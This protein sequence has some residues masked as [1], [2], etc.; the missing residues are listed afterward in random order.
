MIQVAF[1]VSGHG[2]VG[3]LGRRLTDHHLRSDETSCPGDASGPAAPAATDR[4][5]G[6][7]ST[8]ASAHHAPGHRAPGSSSRARP[9]S[10][11]YREVDPQPATD[12]LRT[13]RDTPAAVLAASVA[14]APQGTCGP[15]I[16][17]PS[18]L[19]SVP[20]SPSWTWLRSRWLAASVATFGR[21][22]ARSAF[23]CAAVTR[24]S[25]VPTRVA[26]LRRSSREI[27]DGWRL[28]CR[29][30]RI[31]LPPSTRRARCW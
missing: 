14:P 4:S 3:H 13:P 20:A 18:A 5:A 2:P 29:P 22:A 12:L 10:T 31:P 30:T 16:G 7:R 1:P 26:T 9:A 6:T 17:R 19:V 23:H 25:N 15:G 11:R 8:H 24:Y 27:V 21:R 28:S